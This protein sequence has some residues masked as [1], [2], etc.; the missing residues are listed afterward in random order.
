M[1]Q[2]LGRP[3]LLPQRTRHKSLGSHGTCVTVQALKDGVFRPCVN[4]CTPA[5]GVGRHIHSTI[6]VFSVQTGDCTPG[7]V[8]VT[9]D[10]QGLLPK[11][12]KGL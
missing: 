3:S 10:P 6:H 9:G 12:P 8:R 11:P 2:T 5:S 4:E 1:R 7:P